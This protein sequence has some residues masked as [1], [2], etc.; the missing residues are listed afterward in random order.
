VC[1]IL[2]G[3][4]ITLVLLAALLGSLM[5]LEPIPLVMW[6]LFLLGPSAIGAGILLS[7]R[8][9]YKAPPGGW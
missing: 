6:P 7:P 4:L 1:L 9:M 3:V 8:G 2:G 5:F